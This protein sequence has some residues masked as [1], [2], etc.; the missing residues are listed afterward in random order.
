[1]SFPSIDSPYRISIPIYYAQHPQL[2]AILIQFMVEREIS[3]AGP[4]STKENKVVGSNCL[5]YLPT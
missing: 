5:I 1:M 2:R 3:R 4:H